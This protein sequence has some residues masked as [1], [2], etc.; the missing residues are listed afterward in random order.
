MIDGVQDYQTAEK[1]V[2]D[3]ANQPFGPF[4]LVNEVMESTGNFGDKGVLTSIVTYDTGVMSF[5]YELYNRQQLDHLKSVADH[6]VN[7]DPQQMEMKR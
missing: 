2:F 5:N 4:H 7:F 3:L 6:V 1:K